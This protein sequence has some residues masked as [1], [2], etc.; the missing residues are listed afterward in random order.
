MRKE[1]LTDK[2]QIM[3][4]PSLIRRI[5]DWRF[6]NRVSSRSNAMRKLLKVAL[7]QLSPDAHTKTATE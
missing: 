4:E 6:E 7:D 1:G 3:I 5:D 2:V